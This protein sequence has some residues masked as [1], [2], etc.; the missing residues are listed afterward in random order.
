MFQHAFVMTYSNQHRKINGIL[1]KYWHVIKNYP[2][3]Q[4]LILEKPR[5]KYRRARTL[6]SKLAPKDFLKSG[7]YKKTSS[8]METKVTGSF[9]YLRKTQMLC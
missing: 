6:K 9:R 2:Y 5:I 7:K 4:D 1:S 8:T 3:L